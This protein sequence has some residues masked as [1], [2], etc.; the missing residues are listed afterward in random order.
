MDERIG[1]IQTLLMRMQN[2][3][4]ILQFIAKNDN[5]Y[6]E[7]VERGED[8]HDKVYFN[9][10]SRTIDEYISR[11]TDRMMALRAKE[12][13]KLQEK[14]YAAKYQLLAD[15]IKTGD[16]ALALKIINSIE[17]RELGKPLQTVDSNIVVTD[18]EAISQAVQSLD[19]GAVAALADKLKDDY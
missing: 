1:V 14:L 8:V 10:S 2:R 17:D 13:P 6:R 15:A 12:L 18:A 19:A 16:K 3:R 5:E 7:M 4:S 9:C 11:A